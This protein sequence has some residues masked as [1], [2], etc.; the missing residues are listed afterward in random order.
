MIEHDPEVLVT[1]RQGG[2]TTRL[3]HHALS[4]GVTPWPHNNRWIVVGHPGS[5]RLVGALLEAL[6]FIRQSSLG[7]RYRHPGFRPTVTLTSRPRDLDYV[8]T[9][10]VWVDDIDMFED[11]RSDF[12]GRNLILVT[13]TA[14][15]PW[16]PIE[17]ALE[18]Q[19]AMDAEQVQRQ[20]MED[21]DRGERMLIHL[22][23]NG[24]RIDGLD[25]TGLGRALRLYNDEM[26]R[27]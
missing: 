11:P 10:P 17:R 22:A 3:L 18:R 2:K 27:W 7:H 23:I 24:Y 25:P 26:E 9:D 20:E 14:K 16:L 12:L 1:D 6:G 21:L 13:A 5:I 15:G 8:T 4:E 19:A